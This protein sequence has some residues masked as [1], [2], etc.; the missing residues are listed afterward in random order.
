MAPHNEKE[1]ILPTIQSSPRPTRFENV[2]RSHPVLFIVLGIYCLFRLRYGDW[3]VSDNASAPTCPQV[4]A[5]TPQ[6]NSDLWNELND[7]ISTS[8]FKQSAI[9]WLGG[10]VRIP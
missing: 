8:S 10:A 7:K 4:D 9:D 3:F 1:G 5:L 6:K 2:K